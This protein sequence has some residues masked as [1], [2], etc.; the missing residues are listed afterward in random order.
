MIDLTVMVCT[1]G[2]VVRYIV[3]TGD[4]GNFTES[5]N[6]FGLI[7]LCIEANIFMINATVRVRWSGRTVCDGEVRGPMAIGMAMVRA[8]R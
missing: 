8:F 1:S 4:K 3:D 5:E 7:T 6:S 2:T